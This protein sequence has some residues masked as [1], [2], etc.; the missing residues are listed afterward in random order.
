MI[1]LQKPTLA[2][3]VSC[4]YL[5]DKQFVQ[6]Y[7][8]AHQVSPQE[9]STLLERG[10]R[11]FGAFFFRPRCPECQACRPIRIDVNQFAPSKSQKR[12]LR[13]NKETNFKLS[14]L[15]YKEEYYRIY[16][17]HS[18]IRFQQESEEKEFATTFFFPAVPA[19][20]SEYS[21]NT[22][23]T[24]VGF[25]DRGENALSSVYFAFDPSSSPLA[26]GTFSILKEIEL[27]RSWNLKWYYLGYTI[28]D[29]PSMAYKARFKPYEL[30]DWDS[31]QWTPP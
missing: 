20:I 1:L 15:E 27:C 28:A 13:K 4:P 3:P 14:S 30:Y 10:W 21:W 24:G 8:F 9:F 18:Q 31:K 23:L 7:F 11:R 25:L 17:A 26:L 19:F 6:E 22:K 5:T 16:Q 12:V 2:Q 29:N